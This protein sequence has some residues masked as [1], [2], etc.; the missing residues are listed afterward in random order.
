MTLIELMF[1]I[2]LLG[3]LFF[4]AIPEFSTWIRNNQIRS[5]ADNLQNG[6]RTAQA[7]ALRRNRV[8][9]FY[10]TNAQPSLA[11]T[12]NANGRNWAVRYVPQVIDTVV[13]PEPFVQGG[14][15]SETGS[16]T[17]Q[18]TSVGITGLCFNSSG[19]LIAGDA[20]STGVA[21]VVCAASPA[22]FD[23]NQPSGTQLRPLRIN[24]ELGGRVRSCDPNRPST[25]PDG[26]PP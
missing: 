16:S 12:A 23:V 26:C 25:A 11:A 21:G 1:T 19:R 22:V 15:L 13:A 7:E 24:V 18:V 4:V 5:V 20:T 10:L 6:I 8:V 17:V 3:I 9:V 2:A 14:K